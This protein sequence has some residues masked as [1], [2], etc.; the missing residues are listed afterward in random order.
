MARAMFAAGG[1][2]VSSS[3]LVVGAFDM[4]NQAAWLSFIH[5]RMMETASRGFLSANYAD[6]LH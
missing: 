4:G 1:F 5:W 6:L 3:W 2:N